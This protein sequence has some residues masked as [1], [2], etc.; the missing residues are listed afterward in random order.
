MDRS[1]RRAAAAE[2]S[3]IASPPPPRPPPRGTRTICRRTTLPREGAGTARNGLSWAGMR[4]TGASLTRRRSGWSRST[5]HVTWSTQPSASQPL[6][7]PAWPP[8]RSARQPLV[9]GLAAAAAHTVPLQ[10]SAVV[11]APSFTAMSLSFATRINL[12][13]EVIEPSPN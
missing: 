9:A 5:S 1:T 4:S 6:L 13:V 7:P 2:A 3:S 8:A 11:M 12:L 10:T